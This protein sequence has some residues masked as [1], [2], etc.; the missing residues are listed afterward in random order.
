MSVTIGSDAYVIDRGQPANHFVARRATQS[1][2]ELRT[3][4][5]R[6]RIVTKVPPLLFVMEYPRRDS[7]SD[8]N[9][10]PFVNPFFI[11]FQANRSLLP[12]AAIP[13]WFQSSLLNDLDI[14]NFHSAVLS[15]GHRVALQQLFFDGLTIANWHL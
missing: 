14:L 9:C 1:Y 11:A 2:N 8:L 10:A 6:Q 15:F 12:A 5:F 4:T 13:N 3:S 7:I